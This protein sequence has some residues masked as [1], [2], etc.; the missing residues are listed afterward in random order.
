MHT[1]VV[2]YMRPLLWEDLRRRVN[3]A[4]IHELR[5]VLGHL[6]IDDNEALHAELQ[7]FVDILDDYQKENDRIR[8]AI[9]NRPA[10]PE[11][12]GRA[13]LLDQLKLLA[14]NLHERQLATPQDRALL[15]YVLSTTSLDS[16]VQNNGGIPMTPRLRDHPSHGSLNGNGVLLRPG[17]ADGGRRPSTASRPP[18]SRGLSSRGS[19]SSTASAPAVLEDLGCVSIRH[20]DSVKARLRDALLEEK[21]QLLDDIEFIQGCLDMEQDLIEEDTKKVQVVVPPLKDLQEFRRKLEQVCLEKVVR[22]TIQ[23]KDSR[24]RRT[25]TT[26]YKNEYPRQRR[27]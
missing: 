27:W 16:D 15:G 5:Q 6:L 1:P 4:E 10:M 17:T 11:P 8:D 9:R 12:P 13:I 23:P 24:H 19:I 21:Q 2:F 7:A 26:M 3:Q 22:G 25:N 18:S 14:S 20:I